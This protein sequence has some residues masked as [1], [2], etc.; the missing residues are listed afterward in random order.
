[1][2]SEATQIKY[3]IVLKDSRVSF[4]ITSVGALAKRIPELA[5]SPMKPLLS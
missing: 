2:D 1:M 3:F 5:S 4:F